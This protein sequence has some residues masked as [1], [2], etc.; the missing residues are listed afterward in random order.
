MYYK[1]KKDLLATILHDYYE[2]LLDT[3]LN[4]RP[5]EASAKS[6][7]AALVTG[8]VTHHLLNP[9][10]I[11]LAGVE[12]HII[13]EPA[14]REALTIREDYIFEIERVIRQGVSDG[15]FF[16]PDIEKYANILFGIMTANKAWYLDKKTNSQNDV[17]C[18][19]LELTLKI[20]ETPAPDISQLI[21]KSPSQHYPPGV[22]SS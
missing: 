13:K 19:Y 20:L 9:Q 21:T 1:G 12:Q 4:N 5:V 14:F 17:V 22:S 3:W 2:D 18:K 16:C 8:H 10:Q 7:W 11:C 15:S 6:N